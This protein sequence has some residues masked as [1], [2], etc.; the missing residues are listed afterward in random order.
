MKFG[1]WIGKKKKTALQSDN[2]WHYAWLLTKI[3]ATQQKKVLL[4]EFVEPFIDET[5]QCKFETNC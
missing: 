3:N 2:N 5:K 4:L 1:Y